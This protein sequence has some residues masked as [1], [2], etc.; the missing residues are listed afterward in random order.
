MV[1]RHHG[2][3]KELALL[4]LPGDGAS[5]LGRNWMGKLQLDWREVHKLLRE[6]GTINPF[7]W[8]PELL[9]DKYIERCEGVHPCETRCQA[10][11][12]QSKNSSKLDERV[13]DELDRLLS[14]NII[15]P[16][17]YSQLVAPIVPSLKSDDIMRICGTTKLR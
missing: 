7:A 9:G 15:E 3:K 8:F 5:L 12:L 17:A 6:K 2:Q 11:V 13:G 16:V 4:V 1:V 14:A 10:D